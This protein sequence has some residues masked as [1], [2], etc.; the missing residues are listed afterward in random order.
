MIK[1]IK[2][3]FIFFIIKIDNYTYFKEKMDNLPISAIIQLFNAENCKA[4]NSAANTAVEMVLYPG[5]PEKRAI[6]ENFYL[7]L[8]LKSEEFI[9]RHQIDGVHSD[10][11]TLHS[12]EMCYKN[13]NA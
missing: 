7:G 9:G 1:K 10:L 6:A 5:Q 11:F 3:I 2:L 12:Y 8:L 4:T 13:G